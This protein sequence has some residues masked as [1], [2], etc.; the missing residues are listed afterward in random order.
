MAR[1]AYQF[2]WEISLA[3][4]EWNP[5]FVFALEDEMVCYQITWH[6]REIWSLFGHDFNSL[7]ILHKY[8]NN[9]RISRLDCSLS[10]HNKRVKESH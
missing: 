6:G 3:G 9:E 5:L 4:N 10:L 1:V 7:R 2:W 8:R